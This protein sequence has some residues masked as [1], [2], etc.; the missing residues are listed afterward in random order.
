M[1]ASGRRAEEEG[2]P[3]LTRGVGGPDVPAAGEERVHLGSRLVRTRD[4]SWNVTWGKGGEKEPARRWQMHARNVA[5]AGTPPERLRGSR[6]GKLSG[7]G[8]GGLVV[9][10][11]PEGAGRVPLL[12]GPGAGSFPGGRHLVRQIALTACLSTA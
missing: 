12:P 8:A 7:P 1:A 2:P 5:C 11:G 4:L 9:W 3:I 6:S 10:G